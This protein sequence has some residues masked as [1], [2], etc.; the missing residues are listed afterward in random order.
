MK[1]EIIKRANIGIYR[2]PKRGINPIISWYD[3][4]R[5]KDCNTTNKVND[6]WN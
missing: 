3:Q 1:E 6:I 4:Y 2:N 5:I